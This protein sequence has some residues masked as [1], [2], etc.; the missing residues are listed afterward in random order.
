MWNKGPFFWCIQE[1][2]STSRI[3]I[4]FR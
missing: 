2:K 1:T 3:D 4:I